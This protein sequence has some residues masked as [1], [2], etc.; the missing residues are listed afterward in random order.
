MRSK[1]A[2]PRAKK[3]ESRRRSVSRLAVASLLPLASIFLPLACGSPEKKHPVIVDSKK[4]KENIVKVNQP[5]V[6]MEQD[7]INA[8]IRS[9]G[10][11]M[12]STG[13]GLR[14]YIFKENPKGK[15]IKLKSIVKIKYKV[16]LLDG[17]VCYTSDEKGLREFAVGADNVESG[18]HEMVQLMHGGEKSIFILPSHLAFGLKGDMRKI[19]PK[20]AV[21]YEI[22]IFDVTNI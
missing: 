2:E 6:V 8:W 16:S 15:P 21:V 20:T 1:S 12:K 22:E 5:A 7:E 9:H 14:Y 11:P 17:T 19:P 3:F 18:V 4:L 10:Y 13:T